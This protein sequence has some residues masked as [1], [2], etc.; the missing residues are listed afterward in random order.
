MNMTR[1]QKLYESWKV[2]AKEAK[3][4]QK[5]AEGAA[6]KARR[7]LAKEVKIWNQYVATK[8]PVESGWTK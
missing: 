2:A 8:Y 1:Y 7:L 5:S 3:A 4:A 6:R